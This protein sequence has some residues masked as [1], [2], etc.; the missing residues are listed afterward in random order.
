MPWV[1]VWGS[2]L[3]IFGGLSFGVAS[4]LGR[5]VPPSQLGLVV[6]PSLLGG[7]SGPPFPTGWAYCSPL[8]SSWLFL[9]V[10]VG[11]HA[12]AHGA[13]AALAFAA[14]LSHARRAPSA[15]L[16]RAEHVACACSCGGCCRGGRARDGV[17]P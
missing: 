15:V 12:H 1:E 9:F 11:E 3:W 5:A 14:T 7:P 10:G 16:T 13:G 17:K 4:H 6:P 2:R 8:S